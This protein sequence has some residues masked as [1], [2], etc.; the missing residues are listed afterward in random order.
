MS[1]IKRIR[2]A[3]Q[4]VGNRA[5]AQRARWQLQAHKRASAILSSSK[6][7]SSAPPTIIN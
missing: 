7:G 5:K 4:W 1:Q 3:R 2:G 6:A